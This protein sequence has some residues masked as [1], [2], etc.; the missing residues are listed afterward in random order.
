VTGRCGRG[1][2]ARIEIRPPS[3]L[4]GAARGDAIGIRR[5]ALRIG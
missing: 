2:P 3:G 5:E 1:S 4:G